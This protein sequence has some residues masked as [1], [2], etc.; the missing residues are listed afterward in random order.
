MDPTN[1]FDTQFVVT[2][3]DPD[4]KKFDRVSRII[5][6][7]PSLEMTL[8]IDIATDVWPV[9]KGQQL[10]FQLAS[11]LKKDAAAKADGAEG[12][13][14]AA[15]AAA[16]RD[17]WRLDQPG[18]GG[19]ADDFDYVMYGKIYRYDEKVSD[20]VTVYGSFGG[21]MMALTGNFRHMSNITIGS[22][23]YLLMR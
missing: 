9:S 3:I 11:T 10:T 14:D 7:S 8:S 15:T 18:N 13:Q 17:A 19:I 22:N 1:L 16:E 4:G 12:E 5:A 6:S 2:Q 23:V 20:E 21:L